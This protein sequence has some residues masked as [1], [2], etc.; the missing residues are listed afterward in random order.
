M[1]TYSM[2]CFRVACPPSW[3]GIRGNMVNAKRKA[4]SCKKLRYLPWNWLNQRVTSSL[5][6][7]SPVLVTEQPQ[8]GRGPAYGIKS[9][10]LE[11]CSGL[12][13]RL[14]LVAVKPGSFKSSSIGSSRCPMMLSRRRS[15]THSPCYGISIS[16][17]RRISR[18]TYSSRGLQSSKQ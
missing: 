8:R 11:G 18:S 16:G 3:P 12:S 4:P 5:S 10:D 2:F 6:L 7:L 13:E 15:T 9:P 14:Y 1:H 17:R